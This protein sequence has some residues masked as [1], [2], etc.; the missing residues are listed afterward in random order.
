MKIQENAFKKGIKA[1][2]PQIGIWNSLC[3][4]IVS[5]ILSTAGFDW[6]L[7]DMEHSP[8]SLDTVLGQMQGYQGSKTTPI[9]RPPWSEPVI[10]KRL[11]D[12]GAFTILFPMIQNKE[13]AEAAVRACRY[14]PRGIRGVSLSHR[15]N[16][17]GAAGVDYLARAEEEICILV[18]IETP[19]AMGR[20]D[21]IAAVDGVDGV[22]FGPADLSMNMGFPGQMGH[23]EVAKSISEGAGKARALGKPTGILIPDVEA[24]KKWVEEGFMFV[25]CGSDQ[26][27]LAGAARNLYKQMVPEGDDGSKALNY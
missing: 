17:Y 8:S 1:G 14:P 18:Q 10:T 13:E 24:A 7:L 2:V 25:A 4:N 16:R 20:V 5:D 19:E 26:G 22:F 12:L 23:P 9:V 21:E 3:S 15:G 11:L 6:A 27:L